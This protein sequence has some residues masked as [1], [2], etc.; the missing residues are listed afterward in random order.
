MGLQSTHSSIFVRVVR[1]A[2]TIRRALQLNI[3]KL[4]ELGRFNSSV[5]F[6]VHIS[7]SF[8]IL[9]DQLHLR[10]DSIKWQ[11]IRA[12]T[13]PLRLVHYKKSSVLTICAI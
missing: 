8:F 12:C 6:V 10:Q 4:R 3:D 2:M 1:T 9:A 5:S 7:M 11:Y 13:N